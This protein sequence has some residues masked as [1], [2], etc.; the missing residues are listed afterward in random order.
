MHLTLKVPPVVIACAKV[1]WLTICTHYFIELKFVF[2]ALSQENDW[3]HTEVVDSSSIRQDAVMLQFSYCDKHRLLLL[4]VQVNMI[5][6]HK[7][8]IPGRGWK[9]W[10][11]IPLSIRIYCNN[12]LQSC[13]HDSFGM[14]RR[15]LCGNNSMMQSSIR[16]ARA[17]WNYLPK[18]QNYFIIN[19]AHRW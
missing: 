12:Y 10:E 5:S 17:S 13:Q 8:T 18:S 14:C 19:I 3:T 11:L 6:Q 9:S 16:K 2:F 1:M 4:H 15:Y 7:L